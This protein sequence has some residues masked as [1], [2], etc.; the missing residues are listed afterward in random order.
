MVSKIDFQLTVLNLLARTG[1]MTGRKLREEVNKE[2]NAN[3][4]GPSFYERMRIM[5]ETKLVKSRYEFKRVD[6]VRIREAVYEINEI[7]KR[8][9]IDF[10]E[11][12]TRGKREE[13][14]EGLGGEGAVAKSRKRPQILHR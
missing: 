10:T 4:P 12:K 14:E 7:G 1:E 8:K 13:A 9:R 5:E 3:I 6:G 11:E 2:L